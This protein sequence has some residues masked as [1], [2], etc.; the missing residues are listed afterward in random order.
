MKTESAKFHL[1][2]EFKR[3]FSAMNFISDR[4]L[5]RK[6][7]PAKQTKAFYEVYQQLAVAWEFLSLQCRH[8][9]GYRRVRDGKLACRICGHI[10]GTDEQ[11]LPAKGTKAVGRKTS[12]T[13]QRTVADKKAATITEDGMPG[14]GSR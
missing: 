10:K 13:S 9:D 8:W 2:R 14:R 6:R 4:Y 7:A 12:P 3:L 5:A 1:K 11:W